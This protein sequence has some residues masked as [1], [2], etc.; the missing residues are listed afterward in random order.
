MQSF[1]PKIY[2]RD[3]KPE[4]FLVFE[5]VSELEPIIKI[6]DFGAASSGES[7][8]H[9]AFTKG[10]A[11]LA[12]KHGKFSWQAENYALAVVILEILINDKVFADENKWINNEF[13]PQPVAEGFSKWIYPV[14][15]LCFSLDIA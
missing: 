9:L 5:G 1:E 8:E 12:Q 15:R 7:D 3:I 11:P 10:Y 4:N 13:P 6:C 2:H 14:L